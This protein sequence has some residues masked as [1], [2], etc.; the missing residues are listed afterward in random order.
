M[1]IILCLLKSEFPYI[2]LIDSFFLKAHEEVSFIYKVECAAV[3]L[4]ENVILSD[5]YL[6]YPEFD[7]IF[8]LFEINSKDKHPAW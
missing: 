5:K 7:I 1:F 2:L 8:C 4:L 3:D 6:L